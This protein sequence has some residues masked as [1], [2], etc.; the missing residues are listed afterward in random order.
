[1]Y[2]RKSEHEDV[3]KLQRSGTRL[4]L[5][6]LTQGGREGLARKIEK[7]EREFIEAEQKEH[8]EVRA[9][10]ELKATMENAQRTVST[11]TLLTHK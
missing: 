8:N 10:A 2:C 11:H 7:E 6:R 3:D 9:I 5:V 4:F 1:M